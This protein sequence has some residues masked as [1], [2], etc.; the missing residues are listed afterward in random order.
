MTKNTISK[1]IL[2]LAA[3]IVVTNGITQA[4]PTIMETLLFSLDGQKTTTYDVGGNAIQIV[5][6]Q[7]IP[8]YGITT[9]GDTLH[10][11]A[12]NV[13]IKSGTIILA[14]PKM[15]DSNIYVS[16]FEP[17]TAIIYD[18]LTGGEKKNVNVGTQHITDTMVVVDS[19]N[20][21]DTLGVGNLFMTE[22]KNKY[23][24]AN[25]FPITQASDTI[26][27]SDLNDGLYILYLLDENGDVIFTSIFRK[28]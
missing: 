5:S 16:T 27:Y 22:M 4:E 11:L 20:P 15:D 14:S 7:G 12:E 9:S 28:E 19:L 3:L 10:Y 1:L 25:S 8:R 23:G 17:M 24:F 2:A 18:A 26:S 6:T 13:T 21:E